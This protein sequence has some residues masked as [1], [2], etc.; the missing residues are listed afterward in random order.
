MAGTSRSKHTKLRKAHSQ[1]GSRKSRRKKTSKKK[2]KSK[3]RKN[4]SPQS[5]AASGVGGGTNSPHGR[6]PIRDHTPPAASPRSS[7]PHMA[8]PLASA[9]RAS[10]QRRQANASAYTPD[11]SVRR[12]RSTTSFARSTSSRDSQSHPDSSDLN[13]DDSDSSSVTSSDSS[14]SS[15]SSS[16]AVSNMSDASLLSLASVRLLELVDDDEVDSTAFLEAHAQSAGSRRHLSSLLLS[17][18]Q[19]SATGPSA[20]AGAGASAAPTTPVVKPAGAANSPV[21]SAAS[22]IVAAVPAAAAP[23]LTMAD[24]T[25]SLAP[26]DLAAVSNATAHELLAAGRQRPGACSQLCGRLFCCRV[27]GANAV[28]VPGHVFR[29]SNQRV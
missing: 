21:K 10:P 23:M 7:T 5:G 22:S 6:L 1:A 20:G 3:H 19:R 26:G 4:A 13:S 9:R 12:P 28:V 16:S 11:D 29:G 14:V 18:V 24:V 17:G 27:Y 25:A 8:S 2:R 15:G